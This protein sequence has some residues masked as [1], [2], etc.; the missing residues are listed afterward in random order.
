MS[1][2]RWVVEVTDGGSIKSARAIITAEA[3]GPDRTRVSL[4]TR[5]SVGFP[6]NLMAPLIR[7]RFRRILLSLIDGLET[8]L[9]TGKLI[10]EGGSA[11]REVDPVG[12]VPASA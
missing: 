7:R 11:G 1:E 6:M 10:E 2:G 3:A 12:L 9:R 5:L 8:H 4:D